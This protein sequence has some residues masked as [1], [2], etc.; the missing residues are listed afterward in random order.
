M[1]LG[2]NLRI[3]DH[4]GITGPVPFL[5]IHVDRDNRLFID[6][7]AIR[8]G[9]DRQSRQAHGLL[10]EFFDEVLRLRRSVIP[11]DRMRCTELLNHLHEPNETRLGM[12]ASGIGGKA[13]GSG[14]ADDLGD[15]LGSDPAAQ[16]AVLTRLE[17]LP[18]F[19]DGIGP[20]LI[21]DLTTRIV[22]EILVDFTMDMVKSYPSLG[23]TQSTV[24]VDCYD[25]ISRAWKSRPV[26][27]PFV[28][29]HQLLLVPK[30]WA[31]SRLVMGP[32]PFFNRFTSETVKYERGTFDAK[33][34]FRGPSKKALGE[35]F[36]HKRKLNTDQAVKY[37]KTENRNLVSEY[38]TYVD[39]RFE[40]LSDT[41]I[42]DRTV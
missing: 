34:K 26:Q 1:R 3:T 2:D 7:S 6:P 39:E 32:S 28:A 37:M 8:N 31:F 9:T 30:A 41:E 25:P 27:L 21:S 13:L 20:D 40:P 4:F 16:A 36:P 5:N 23:Q 11:S 42:D 18:L 22:F 10:V 15:L 29:P 38:Q 14:L 35:E 24:D 19:I 17:H 33:G 12:S